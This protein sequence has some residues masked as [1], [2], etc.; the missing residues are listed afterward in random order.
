MVFAIRGPRRMPE[1]SQSEIVRAERI[2]TRDDDLRSWTAQNSRLLPGC[3]AK[4]DETT[5]SLRA[6]PFSW[7]FRR[8]AAYAVAP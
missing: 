5:V 1:I 6:T 3:G 8:S 2:S 4:Q 7:Q